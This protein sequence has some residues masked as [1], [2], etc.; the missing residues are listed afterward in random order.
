MFVVV[1]FNILY[2]QTYSL[3]LGLLG[4]I[5]FKDIYLIPMVGNAMETCGFFLCG[6]LVLF[7]VI[8]LCLYGFFSLHLIKVWIIFILKCMFMSL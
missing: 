4:I 3:R 7:I 6:I 5:H 2:N 8:S 1:E